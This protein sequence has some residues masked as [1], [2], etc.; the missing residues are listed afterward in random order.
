MSETIVV[1]VN[2]QSTAWASNH[3]K[4][5]AFAGHLRNEARGHVTA[6]TVVELS[7]GDPQEA[8]DVTPTGALAAIV[9]SAGPSS[10]WQLIAAPGHVL[11]RFLDVQEA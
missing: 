4:P 2:G 10:E 1:S 7:S 6:G 9:A 8:G 3:G 11:A 5:G